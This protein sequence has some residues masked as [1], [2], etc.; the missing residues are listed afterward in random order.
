MPHSKKKSP[1]EKTESIKVRLQRARAALVARGIDPD[2]LPHQPMAAPHGKTLEARD[3]HKAGQILAETIVDPIATSRQ[4]AEQYGVSEMMVKGMMMR[5]RT[6]ALAMTEE[7]HQ[8]NQ[9]KL[10]DVVDDRLMR[11]LKYLDDYQM[12][13]ASARDLAYVI[14]RLFNMRQLI[15]GEPTQIM[16]HDER[17]ALADLVPL[18]VAEARRRGITIDGT[19]VPAPVAPIPAPLEVVDGEFT[20]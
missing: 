17:R 10:S 16:G 18:M 15:R 4:I 3:P 2:N 14:D 12:A 20:E 5:L 11:A 7:L 8:V 13:G 19:A 6:T 9:K 1:A